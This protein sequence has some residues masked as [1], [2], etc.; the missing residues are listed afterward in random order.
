MTTRHSRGVLVVALLVGLTGRAYAA[1]CHQFIQICEPTN[2][3]PADCRQWDTLWSSPFGA[4]ALPD[5]CQIL[6]G[7]ANFFGF[8]QWHG[9]QGELPVGQTFRPEQSTL[10]RIDVV[11]HNAVDLAPITVQLWKWNDQN[12]NCVEDDAEYD[13]TTGQSPVWSDTITLPG[14]D[15]W[16]MVPIFPNLTGLSTIPC[17]PGVSPTT[18]NIYFLQFSTEPVEESSPVPPHGEWG[19]AGNDPSTGVDRYPCGKARVGGF[20]AG[21]DLWFK[22]YSGYG[23]ALPLPPFSPSSFVSWQP[24]S[25]TGGTIF[26]ADFRDLLRARADDPSFFYRP[27]RALV[28]AFLHN[29]GEPGDHRGLAVAQFNQAILERCGHQTELHFEFQLLEFAGWAY[30][31]I[32][33]GLPGTDATRLKKYLLHSAHRLYPNREG[34][35]INRTLATALGMKLVTDLVSDQ[36]F[37]ALSDAG[38]AFPECTEPPDLPELHWF[39]QPPATGPQ[40]SAADRAEWIAYASGVWNEFKTHWDLAEDASHY[41]AIDQRVL[42]QLIDL[43]ESDKTAFW[44]TDGWKGFVERMYQKHSVVGPSA[45]Y[46][47]SSGLNFDWGAPTWFFAEAGIRLGDPRYKALAFR[48]F[49]YER[50]HAD[51]PAAE[52][53]T[54]VVSEWNTFAHAYFA[55]AGNSLANVTPP[56]QTEHASVQQSIET[57]QHNS[58]LTGGLQRLGQ[59][60]TAVGSPLVKL[61]LKL[62][63]LT[64][65]NDATLRIYRWRGSYALTTGVPPLYQKTF[66]VAGTGN[67]L[68]TF[69]PFL[70]D[71][72][73]PS[74]PPGDDDFVKNQTYYFEVSRS[75][76]FKMA[77]ASGNLYT[78]GHLIHNGLQNLTKDLWFSAYDLT[79]NGSTYTTHKLT[80]GVPNGQ[81]ATG[82]P[83]VYYPFVA[84]EEQVPDKLALRSGYDPLDLHAI[85]NLTVSPRNHG[86]NETG[87][88]LSLFDKGSLLLTDSA[89]IDKQ[90]KDG[91]MSMSRRFWPTAESVILPDRSTVSRFADSRSSTVAWVDWPDTNGWDIGWQRRFYFVKN[92]FLLV[93]DRAFFNSSMQAKVGVLWH[94]MDTDQ[95]KG[96]DWFNLYAHTPLVHPDNREFKNTERYL[97][98]KTPIRSV[99]GYSSPLAYFDPD[100][101]GSPPT[102]AQIVATDWTGFAG[103]ST[104]RWFDSLLY[105][106]KTDPTP[107]AGS[108]LVEAISSVIA[109]DHRRTA[110][111]VT[112][113]PQQVFPEIWYI[114]D[115]PGQTQ[116]TAGGITTDAGYFIAMTMNGQL[117]YLL[118]YQATNVSVSDTPVSFSRSW[119][120]RTSVEE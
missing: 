77:G 65:S 33:N 117:Q 94:A 14:A 119:P 99:S 9:E 32:E 89:R 88:V 37:V 43:Y 23:A 78:G 41:E 102:P 50:T 8:T 63:R 59:T 51:V 60:F 107:S 79:P 66:S 5:E 6:T 76:S 70:S 80:R 49:D 20:L 48:V 56:A 104:E 82:V 118:T 110:F 68:Y 83:R 44:N 29:V 75:T 34:S 52:L 114:V 87:A 38:E 112:V 30:K 27:E 85:V 19:L 40:L 67:Q 93:R 91:S 13:S 111:K 54:R 42:L 115:N 46:G 100:P 109:S 1:D 3:G 97:L 53:Y 62:D 22:T 113:G 108:A 21:G 45:V 103:A 4:T 25:P 71:S 92:R 7:P 69:R 16:V 84:P 55:L 58:S 86:H 96:A 98:L 64:T 106:H 74:T 2:C 116:F 90:P 11:F 72:E 26:P 47:D 24:P 81:Q 39:G 15:D 95:D 105:P 101:N 31:W 36:E 73:T 12:Q 17:T 120:V 61:E 10:A 35:T 28:H 18:H 57:A